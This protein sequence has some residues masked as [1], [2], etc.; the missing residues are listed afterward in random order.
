MKYE[1]HYQ[2]HDKSEMI[3]ENEKIECFNA[4]STVSNHHT[5]EKQTQ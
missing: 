4:S 1:I 3:I 5:Q 2:L